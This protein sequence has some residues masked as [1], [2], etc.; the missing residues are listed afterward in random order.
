M[1]LLAELGCFLRSVT[2]QKIKVNKN[3]MRGKSGPVI[4]YR[5]QMEVSVHLSIAI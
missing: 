1:C 5:D 2:N 3:F 4:C